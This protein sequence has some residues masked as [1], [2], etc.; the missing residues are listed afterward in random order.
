LLSGSSKVFRTVAVT[1]TS[2]P[3]GDKRT[4]HKNIGNCTKTRLAAQLQCPLRDLRNLDKAAGSGAVILPRPGG[5]ICNIPRFK[6]NA[7]KLVVLSPRRAPLGGGTELTVKAFS[8]AGGGAGD[9]GTASHTP[10]FLAE[11]EG[12]LSAAYIEGE[13]S[14]AAGTKFHLVALEV[15]LGHALR[16][17]AKECGELANECREVSGYSADREARAKRAHKKES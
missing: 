3:R 9:S 12:A 10:G 11:L 17:L 1:L 6:A 7:T 2:S 16:S 5:I 15:L 4:L 13:E 8:E 14:V